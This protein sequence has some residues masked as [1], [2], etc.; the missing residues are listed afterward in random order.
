[1]LKNFKNTKLLINL[2]QA[3]SIVIGAFIFPYAQ[4]NFEYKTV[5]LQNKEIAIQNFVK[6]INLT[7]YYFDRVTLDQFN[8]IEAAS[9]SEKEVFTKRIDDALDTLNKIEYPYETSCALI[10]VNFS[11][12]KIRNET[13]T[14]RGYL[15]GIADTNWGTNG[16]RAEYETQRVQAIKA[17]EVLIEDLTRQLEMKRKEYGFPN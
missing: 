2:L 11:D 17:L 13:N 3:A 16:T 15:N 4:N 9:E 8:K 7:L 5:S 6:S 14:L 12:K 1:M 10:N